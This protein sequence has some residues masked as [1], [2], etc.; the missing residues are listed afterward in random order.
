MLT[1]TQE[2]KIAIS[3]VSIFMLSFSVLAIFLGQGEVSL[4]EMSASVAHSD[5]HVEEV[6]ELKG[7]EGPAFIVNS[8]GKFEET[9]EEFC[10]LLGEN[11]ENLEGTAFFEY[12]HIKDIANF[13]SAHTKVV[14][15]GVA[16]EGIGP[17]RI[18]TEHKKLVVLVDIE[19]ILEDEKVVKMIFHVRD[20][21]EQ[22]EEIN[23]DSHDNVTPEDTEENP[24]IRHMEKDNTHLLAEKVSFHVDLI[25]DLF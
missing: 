8:E 23:E 16:V 25:K 5:A 10:W 11:C 4:E 13:I 24:T 22:I 6:S 7:V 3:V 15:E 18:I 20:L 19:P 12:I 17:L 14:Q 1:L 9:S 2:K 21:T